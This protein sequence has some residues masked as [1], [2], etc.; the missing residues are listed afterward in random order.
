V[1]Y[2][3]KDIGGFGWR[4]HNLLTL[5]VVL[6]YY[7]LHQKRFRGKTILFTIVGCLMSVILHPYIFLLLLPI[8]THVTIFCKCER[9]FRLHNIVWNA[10]LLLHLLTIL[11]AIMLLIT[12]LRGI[13]VLLRHILLLNTLCKICGCLHVFGQSRILTCSLFTSAFHFDT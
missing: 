3:N 6:F 2:E 4:G 5:V 10:S 13:E 12:S 8:V 7:E 11:H 9:S 1:H